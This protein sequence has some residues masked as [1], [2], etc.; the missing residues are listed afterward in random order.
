[1]QR[2]YTR[3][4]V[5]TPSAGTR[6]VHT[7]YEVTDGQQV[8]TRV[9]EAVADRAGVDPLELRPPLYDVVDPEAI[10]A[11]FEPTGSGSPRRGRLE[12]TY[13]GYRITLTAGDRRSVAVAEADSAERDHGRESRQTRA[14]DPQ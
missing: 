7:E 8:S 10:D 11:L 9:V 6:R 3:R 1:M 4:G 12:F 5:F 14:S 13:H 2:F